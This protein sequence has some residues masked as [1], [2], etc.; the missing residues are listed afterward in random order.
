MRALGIFNV[1][2]GLLGLL[3]SFLVAY[4]LPENPL[5]RE[6]L[7]AGALASAWIV[8]TG[9]AMIVWGRRLQTF[10]GRLV[11]TALLRVRSA[12]A[13]AWR[14]MRVATASNRKG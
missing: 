13:H 1:C 4:V 6:A 10:L 14:R 8:V 2:Y 9:T 5:P 3:S 11:K 12:G 7:I